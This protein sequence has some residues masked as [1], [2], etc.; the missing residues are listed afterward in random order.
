MFVNKINKMI[1]SKGNY[2]NIWKFPP[3]TLHYF[4]FLDLFPS[5]SNRAMESTEFTRNI[6]STKI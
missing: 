3:N 1:S 2:K 5:Q 6:F 4:F